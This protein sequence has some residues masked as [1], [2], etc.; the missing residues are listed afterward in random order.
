MQWN[1]ERANEGGKFRYRSSRVFA[2]HLT[3]KEQSVQLS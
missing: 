2:L 3:N 1:V